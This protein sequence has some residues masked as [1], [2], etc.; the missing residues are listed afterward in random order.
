MISACAAKFAWIVL[1]AAPVLQ[2]LPPAWV[3]VKRGWACSVIQPFHTV[4][5]GRKACQR[6]TP[7]LCCVR[8][9]RCSCAMNVLQTVLGTSSACHTVVAAFFISC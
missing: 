6:D 4:L 2:F 7:T 5:M 9:Q 3:H 1:R 8:G